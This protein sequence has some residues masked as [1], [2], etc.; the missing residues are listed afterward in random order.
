ML[1]VPVPPAVVLPVPAAVVLPAVLYQQLPVSSITTLTG[2]AFFRSVPEF[3][4]PVSR[5]AADRGRG[6]GDLG[7]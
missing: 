6:R 4:F 3:H 5:T 7:D 2:R 1:A